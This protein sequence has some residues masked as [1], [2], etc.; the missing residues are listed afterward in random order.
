MTPTIAEAFATFVVGQRAARALHALPRLPP[1]VPPSPAAGYPHCHWCA[2][3]HIAHTH[4]VCDKPCA[5]E[6]CPADV[7]AYQPPPVPVFGRRL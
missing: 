5:V 7:N 4:C 2:S 6:R 1:A 3:T